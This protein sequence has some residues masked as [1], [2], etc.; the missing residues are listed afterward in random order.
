MAPKPGMAPRVNSPITIRSC[1]LPI[2]SLLEHCFKILLLREVA[3]AK[4]K[5]K[6]VTRHRDPGSSSLR[7]LEGLFCDGTS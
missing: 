1:Q 7:G 6:E 2:A 3:H 4:D 5:Q